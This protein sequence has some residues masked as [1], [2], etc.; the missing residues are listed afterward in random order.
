VPGR[1]AD[2]V[3]GRFPGETS[4]LSMSWAMLDPYMAG[5][6]GLGLSHLEYKQVGPMKIARSHPE[7]IVGK[8]A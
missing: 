7:H 4:C 6:K 5:A 8:V 3:I 2:E 1:A